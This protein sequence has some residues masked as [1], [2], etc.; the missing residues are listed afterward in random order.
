MTKEQID[1]I[2]S[3]VRTWPLDRQNDAALVL[4]SMEA[5]GTGLYRL[6]DAERSE[7]EVSLQEMERGEFATE[8]EVAEVFARHR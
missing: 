2:L 8:K 5:D 1:A 7:I 3:R 6:S 4:L